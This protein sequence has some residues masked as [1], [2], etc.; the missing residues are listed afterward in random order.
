MTLKYVCATAR[1][2][3]AAARLRVEGALF[4]LPIDRVRVRLPVAESMMATREMAV[5]FALSGLAA[6]AAVQTAPWQCRPTNRRHAHRGST[7]PRRSNQLSL[8]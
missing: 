1:V 4:T 5:C 2:M 8:G 3:A 7:R 6:T